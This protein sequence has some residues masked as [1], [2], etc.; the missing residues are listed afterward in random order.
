MVKDHAPNASA[1]L[2]WTLL[3]ETSSLLARSV[4]LDQICSALENCC[5][6]AMAGSENL[7]AGGR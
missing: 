1:V 7:M 2:F 6:Q 4:V 5:K 3:T